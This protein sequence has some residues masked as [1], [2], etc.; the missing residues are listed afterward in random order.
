MIHLLAAAAVY[1]AP[2]PAMNYDWFSAVYDFPRNGIK[3][4]E[5]VIVQVD[6]T[7]NPHGYIQG[8]TG[9]VYA[10]IPQMGPYVCSRLR[11]RGEFDPARDPSGRRMFGVYRTFVVLWTGSKRENFPKDYRHTDFDVSVPASIDLG[12][13]KSVVVQFAVDAQGHTSSCSQ[14]AVVGYG[15]YK[16]KQSVNPAAMSLA[17]EAVPTKLHVEP[18]HDSSG[19]P[20]ASVQNAIVGLKSG[21]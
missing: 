8:C 2:V 14:A 4:N 16:E 11:Q 15:L 6:N 10:G 19:K 17:C 1:S 20:V 12:K 21:N 18:A 9:H 5:L 3:E 13:E 7:I